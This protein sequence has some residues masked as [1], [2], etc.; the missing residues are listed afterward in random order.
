MNP[1]PLAT[2]IHQ[3]QVQLFQS[4]VFTATKIIGFFYLFSPFFLI[5]LD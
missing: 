4:S 5:I 3:K 2:K 1:S